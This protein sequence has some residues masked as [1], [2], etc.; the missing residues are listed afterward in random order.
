MK[1]LITGGAGFVGRWVL[2]ELAGSGN[3]V[4]ALTRGR[5]HSTLGISWH[6]NDLLREPARLVRATSPT[7]L[8][9]LAW[10]TDPGVYTHSPD[11]AAWAAASV[12]LVKA[13]IT[14]GGRH[15]LI[16]GTCAEYALPS[17]TPCTE[18]ESPLSPAT[19]YAGFKHA[20]HMTASTLA[21]AAGV[22]LCWARLF[23]LFG[24]H[25]RP[26]RL[27]PTI[28]R[29]VA[30]GQPV[31]LGHPAARRDYMSTPDAGQALATLARTEASGAI[32]V[33][34]GRAIR[35]AD[36]AARIAELMG[37][38]HPVNADLPNECD[39]SVVA[40]VRRLRQLGIAPA[41]SLDD[42]LRQTIEWWQA[43]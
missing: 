34:S 10:C 33:A 15:M 42:R 14:G 28:I 13:F 25:E 5:P 6:S 7:H 8:I 39:D 40:D 4:H 26:E 16:A 20:L 30:A 9:H 29:S 18:N 12:E 19:P 22:G 27:V 1:I 32:N 31:V 21:D 2:A 36:L 38:S 3:E 11:N 17:S 23:Y 37:G 43:R 24:P 41:T 35:I